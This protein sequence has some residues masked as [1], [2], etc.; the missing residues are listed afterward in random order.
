MNIFSVS[1]YFYEIPLH[2]FIS[3][4]LVPVIV[5]GSSLNITE[6]VCE[7]K[8]ETIC[9]TKFEVRLSFEF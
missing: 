8:N 7:L 1:N 3:I 6:E 2:T 5:S 9:E 4:V